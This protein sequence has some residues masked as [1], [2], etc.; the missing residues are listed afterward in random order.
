MGRVVRQPS[1]QENAWLQLP[2]KAERRTSKLE[3]IRQNQE[4]Y[5]QLVLQTQ[6]GNIRL[7]ICCEFNEG[8][9]AW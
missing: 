6:T 7:H 9:F 2:L 1:R 5:N 8:F 4:L 3:T